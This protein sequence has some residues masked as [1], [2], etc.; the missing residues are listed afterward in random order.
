MIY[1]LT[2]RQYILAMHGYDIQHQP[3][4]GEEPA[5]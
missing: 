1:P 2:L 4:A 5:F 3:K